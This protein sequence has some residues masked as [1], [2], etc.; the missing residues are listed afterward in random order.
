MVAPDGIRAHNDKMREFPGIGVEQR[1][2]GL[3]ADLP[4]D[5]FW[6]AGKLNEI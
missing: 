2:F 4:Y 5:V 1:Y 3:T 6:G